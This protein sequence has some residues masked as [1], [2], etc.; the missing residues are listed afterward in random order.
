VPDI[1]S[2]E[3]EEVRR[4]NWLEYKAKKLAE[5]PVRE[6]AFKIFKSVE[7]FSHTGFK[8]QPKLAD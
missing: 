5:G 4:S 2:E 3:L 1:T 6:D 7:E 8:V